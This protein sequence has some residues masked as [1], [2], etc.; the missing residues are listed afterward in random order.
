MGYTKRSKK[1]NEWNEHLVQTYEFIK[2]SFVNCKP[3]FIPDAKKLFVVTTNGSD[4]AIGGYVSQID[5]TGKEKII[6][7]YSKKLNRSEENIPRM[8]KNFYHL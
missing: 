8:I 3:K 5:A 7:Y 4:K 6:D 1:T 2:N